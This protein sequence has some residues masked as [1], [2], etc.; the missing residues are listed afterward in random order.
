MNNKLKA[1]L[2]FL[3]VFTTPCF[4]GGIKG[5]LISDEAIATIVI[6]IVL[7]HIFSIVAYV[8]KVLWLRV[9]CGVLYLPIFLI[10]LGLMFFE[11]GFAL[12]FIPTV[13]FYIFTI[14]KTRKENEV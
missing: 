8:G 5:P 10:P 3:L 6:C 1:L 12:L 13:L 2:F 9:L 4:A 7:V 11:E 14:V